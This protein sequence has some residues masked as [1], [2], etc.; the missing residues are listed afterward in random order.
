MGSELLLRDVGRRVRDARTAAGI[1]QRQLA[2]LS[3]VSE[4]LV[5]SVESGEARSISVDRLAAILSQLGLDLRVEERPPVETPT[6]QD[7]L[8]SSLLRQAVASWNREE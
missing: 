5:R 1:T 3:G 8:Y 4:R 7:A 6:E 2:A